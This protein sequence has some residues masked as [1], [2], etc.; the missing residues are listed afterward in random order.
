MFLLTVN[1]NAVLK[2]PTEGSVNIGGALKR[3][4]ELKFTANKTLTIENGINIYA[5]KLNETGVNNN[6]TLIFKGDSIFSAKSDGQ[7]IKAIEIQGDGKTTE[8]HQ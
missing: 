1:E 5:A 8:S 3:L 4:S 6:G 7:N 2:A